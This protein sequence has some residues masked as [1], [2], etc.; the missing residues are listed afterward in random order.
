M[1]SKKKHSIL[2]LLLILV[3]L[4]SFRYM[5]VRNNRT[6]K[7]RITIVLPENMEEDISSVQEGIR[8]YA[9]D[10]QIQLDV[11]YEDQMS[12][13]KFAELVK[14]EKRN[15]S[16]GILLIYPEMYL[17]RKQNSYNYDEVLALTDTMKE[18]FLHYAAFVRRAQEEETYRMPISETVLGQ[19]K[20]GR[21]K[22]VYM[23][24]TYRLGYE[25]MQM[26]EAYGKKKKMESIFLQPLK[27]D[28]EILEA[29]SLDALLAR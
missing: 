13:E 5:T 15:K 3:A 19:I 14:D 27:L 21:K 26:I 18:S 12:E 22:V 11:W 28:R 23:E 10:H 2:I 1:N 17:E 16:I 29:G 25:C 20:S 4:V 9:Y 8:D 6:E 7:S 24:N